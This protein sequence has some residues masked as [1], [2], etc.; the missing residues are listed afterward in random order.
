MNRAP[1][2]SNQHSNQRKSDHRISVS[3]NQ[4]RLGVLAAPR[5]VRSTFL[6]ARLRSAGGFISDAGL[7]PM[8]EKSFILR[9][10]LMIEITRI[11]RQR[12]K[13]QKLRWKNSASV[14]KILI[15]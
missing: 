12:L 2:Q 5:E 8:S 15:N 3:E 14:I 9:I 7:Y 6:I 11:L 10:H 13:S 4:E 1:E